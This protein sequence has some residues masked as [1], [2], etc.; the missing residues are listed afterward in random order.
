MINSAWRIRGAV[1]VFGRE[2]YFYLLHFE[3]LDDLLHIC[4][5]GPWAVDGE[6]LVLERWRPNLVIRNLQLNFVS[7]W[8][9]IHGLP[10][11]YQ[12]PELAEKMGQLMG[13]VERVDWEDKIPRNIR[14]M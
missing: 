9:Q 8:V 12:Y 1:S 6:L 13:I 14:F 11:E 10:L 2:S 5:E 3:S 4:S 7:I